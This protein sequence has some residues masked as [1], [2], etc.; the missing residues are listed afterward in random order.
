MLHNLISHIIV[1]ILRSWESPTG[2]DEHGGGGGDGDD[3][4][5]G[6]VPSFRANV[7]YSLYGILKG[8]TDS[9]CNKRTFINSFHTTQGLE[10]FTNAMAGAGLTDLFEIYDGDGHDDSVNVVTSSCNQDDEESADGDD[11]MYNGQKYFQSTSYGLGCSADGE[12]HFAIHTYIG[13]YC[14]AN[15]IAA[16]TDQLEELN[17][18][19]SL[20][21]CVPIYTGGYYSMDDDE[22]DSLLSMS[23][24]HLGLAVSTTAPAVVQIPTVYSRSAK[25]HSTR[26]QERATR[27]LTGLSIES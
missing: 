4:Y 14:D 13:A 25:R 5:M 22:M 18:N 3:W 15:A 24:R 2:N 16:T 6:S 7:A 23:W 21:K 19:L 11:G 20:S 9:G 10:S 17:E 1:S 12:Q 8:D 27:D 26:Q